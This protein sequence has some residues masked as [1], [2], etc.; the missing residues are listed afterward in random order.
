MSV[1]EID[2]LLSSSIPSPLMAAL[3]F[4]FLTNELHIIPSAT[5][6]TGQQP[7]TIQIGKHFFKPHVDAIR[8][9]FVQVKA[10]GS[11]TAEEWLKGLDGRG[12]QHRNDAARWERY[13]VTGGTARMC[14]IEPRETQVSPLV[15]KVATATTSDPTLS[16]R[17]SSSLPAKP[18]SSSL[19]KIPPP[20]Q[21]GLRGYPNHGEN[22]V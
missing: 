22:P 17:A 21:T 7:P 8:T 19:P 1:Q 6:Q 2:L 9:E 20:M 4:I 3:P 14:H 12:K 16:S 18:S 15:A 11:A 5:L 13:E 10:M